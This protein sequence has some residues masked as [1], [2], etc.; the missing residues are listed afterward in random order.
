MN[1]MIRRYIKKGDDISKYSDKYIKKVE[2]LLNN[3]PRKSL[4]YKTPL[5]VMKENNLIKKTTP[6]HYDEVV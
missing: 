6:K 2:N 1:K 5:E 3:M 4:G